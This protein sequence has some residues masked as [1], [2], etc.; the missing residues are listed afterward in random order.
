M[1]KFGQ[2]TLFEQLAKKVW[3]I[4]RS[5]KRLLIVS[6]NINGFSLVSHRWFAKFTK[7]S[8]YTVMPYSCMNCKFKIECINTMLL[9]LKVVTLIIYWRSTNYYLV[10]W[11]LLW[12]QLQITINE[13]N[14]KATSVKGLV[15]S[16]DL[17]N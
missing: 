1:G 7:L 11:L 15:F 3:Q 5:V 13:F 4:N 10:P 2:F 17:Y 14:E 8:H 6:T 12:L 16:T 9:W